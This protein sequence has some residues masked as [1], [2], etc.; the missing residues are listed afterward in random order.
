MEG[1]VFDMLESA[2]QKTLHAQN[3]NRAST[4]A[5]HVLTDLLA[6]Y[7]SLLAAT[8]VRN[9]EHAGRRSVSIFDVARS[10]DSMGVSVEELADFAEGEGRDLVRY[11]TTTA[12]RAEELA[13]LKGH[14]RFLRALSPCVSII[15]LCTFSDLLQ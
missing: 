8:C 9:A 14:C 15:I 5:T 11:A 4:Q 13:V 10:L 6:R 7:M 3:F 1:A 12:R 2:T